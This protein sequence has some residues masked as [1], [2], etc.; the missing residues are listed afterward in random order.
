MAGRLLMRAYLSSSF[1]V[2][3]STG[4]TTGNGPVAALIGCGAPCYLVDYDSHLQLA[5]YQR[6]ASDLRWALDTYLFGLDSNLTDS[7][8][9][10]ALESLEAEL[11][12]ATLRQSLFNI[13][14]T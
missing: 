2:L 12:N 14:S 1:E 5:A 3:F 4:Q 9:L 6:A 8:R 11:V 13:V 7:T 10:A